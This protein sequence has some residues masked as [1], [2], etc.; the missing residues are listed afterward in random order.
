M[1]LD[2]EQHVAE[3]AEHMRA[4]RLAL[5]RAGDRP[6]AGL[7]G[8]HAE[9]VRPEPDQPLDE[10]DA[11]RRA[12]RRC[13]PWPRRDR[14][15]AARRAAR[16]PA[17][18]R[19]SSP[20]SARRRLSAPLSLAS[21]SFA[22]RAAC[23]AACCACRNSKALR[24][25]AP[26]VSSSGSVRRPAPG[27]SSSASSAPRGSEAMA[28]IEPGRGPSPNRCS[29]S[30]ASAFGSRAMRQCPFRL[31]RAIAPPD[32]RWSAMRMSRLRR[33]SFRNHVRQMK[34]WNG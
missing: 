9:M 24:A 18:R 6:H 7:V 33:S 31:G 21:L 2:R 28:A 23:R 5:E 14:A 13:A 15:A 11:R 12:R 29:A 1:A 16:A 22:S 34:N 26:L 19:A 3:A 4:D 32:L 8:R 25:A 20:A 30:A 27:R 17:D 10:A